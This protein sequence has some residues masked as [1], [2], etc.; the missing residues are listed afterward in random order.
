MEAQPVTLEKPTLV[1]VIAWMTLASGI[2]NILW[3]FI[4]TLALIWT[5]VCIPFTVLPTIL[6]I[7]EVIYAAKLLS[8]P[9]QAVQPSTTL[10]ILEVICVFALNLFSMVVGIL[11]LVFY[12]D[13]TVKEYFAQ[14]N[15]SL[16]PVEPAPLAP[17]PAPEP[18]PVEDTLQGT[19]A[20]PQEA[21]PAEES[22]AP[23][24]E[25][26]P[27]KPKRSRKVAGK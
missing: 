26:T 22:P 14:L 9:P 18:E 7:F 21:A 19:P 8:N 4:A 15:G 20:A 12:N 6:G 16:I 27:E 2:V 1:N 11:A 17:T 10:A 23:A 5:I 25:E 13:M 24:P 3:G